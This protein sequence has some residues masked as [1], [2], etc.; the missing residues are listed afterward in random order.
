MIYNHITLTVPENGGEYH[1]RDLCP[2][3]EPYLYF[4]REES[5]VCSSES[6]GCCGDESDGSKENRCACGSGCSCRTSYSNDDQCFLVGRI[7]GTDENGK[8]LFHPDEQYYLLNKL[9]LPEPVEEYIINSKD[10]GLVKVPRM[11]SHFPALIELAYNPVA[12]P[13]FPRIFFKTALPEIQPEDIIRGDKFLA[14]AA[15]NTSK[16]TDM[17]LETAEEE[18]AVKLLDT[19]SFMATGAPGGMGELYN[20]GRITG[21]LAHSNL[22]EDDIRGMF[23]AV[24]EDDTRKFLK[25]WLEP[26]KD[27]HVIA[28]ITHAPRSKDNNQSC[29]RYFKACDIVTDPN[30]V[31][32]DNSPQRMVVLYSKKDFSPVFWHRPE[33]DVADIS[34]VEE[35]LQLAAD[36]GLK[37]TETCRL[38]EDIRAM[39]HCRAPWTIE[40]EA[41]GIGPTDQANLIARHLSRMEAY[42]RPSCCTNFNDSPLSAR[43]FVFFMALIIRYQMRHILYPVLRNFN[44]EFDEAIAI[45]REVQLI[46]NGRKLTVINEPDAQQIELIYQTARAAGYTVTNILSNRP[47]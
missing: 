33:N 38:I 37:N 8:L 30:A 31:S 13:P 46:R 3:G 19:A 42:I 21:L 7:C 45:I 40:D 16:L 36:D 23:S 1:A 27:D 6:G 20:F 12:E 29:T 26:R 34:A 4:V 15:S 9:P 18:M 10:E 5:T 43:A 35:C 22:M 47:E 2:E 11:F 24:S 41:D 39:A 28:C 17:M 14:H 44:I 32:K 25:L